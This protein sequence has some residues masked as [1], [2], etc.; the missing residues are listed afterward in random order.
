MAASAAAV[1]TIAIAA[2]GRDGDTRAQGVTPIP[3]AVHKLAG[4]RSLARKLLPKYCSVRW[5]RRLRNWRAATCE[6]R[7]GFGRA[8]ARVKSVSC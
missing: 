8:R 3:C 6:R 4:G 2:K 1:S 5:R 7:V